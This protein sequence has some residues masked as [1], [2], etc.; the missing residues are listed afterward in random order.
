[1]RA[2]ILAAGF[3]TRLRP[4]TDSIPKPLVPVAGVPNIVRVIEHLKGFGITE[5]VVNLHHLAD[6][7]PAELGDGASLG[8]SIVY[9]REDG[10]ILGTGGG[11]GKALP[12][13]G[14]ETFAVVNGDVLF[15]PDLDRALALHRERGALATM[16]VRPD[17]EAEKLGPV[18]LDA[19]GRVR[20]LVWG[21][22]K[23][24]GQRTF[25][26][27]G[28]HL[29]EPS[30]GDRL[31]A[32]GCI[33]RE[34][35]IPMV[36]EGAPLFGVEDGG[37]FCDMGTPK[38]LV[39]AVADVVT[40]VAGVPWYVPSPAGVH[41]AED[42]VVEEGCV[43]GPGTSVCSGARVTG[44]ACLERVLVMPGANVDFDASD[45]IICADGTVL[46]A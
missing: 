5:L 7:I 32:D 27:T 42:A 12:L 46:D 13:L 37:Y 28:V 38:R 23:A 35:Y 31:P 39:D 30:I 44:G 9:S 17:P 26:F 29:V 41:V 34:T 8:V 33:V 21:G 25:M 11:I 14:D 19:D 40:G 45:A 24:A 43:I 2:M 18:G 22:A 1:M 36:D 16:V 10:K 6:A 3:G 15:A 4:I 20:R